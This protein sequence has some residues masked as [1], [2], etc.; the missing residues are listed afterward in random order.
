M[1][2]MIVSPKMKH[3]R[4]RNL[5]T[6]KGIDRDRDIMNLETYVRQNTTKA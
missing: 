6:S 2:Y 4:R 5:R 3:I 1:S